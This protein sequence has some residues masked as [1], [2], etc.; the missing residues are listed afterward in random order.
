MACGV[1][2]DPV[3]QMLDSSS[4]VFTFM[5]F[6]PWYPAAGVDAVDLLGKARATIGSSQWQFAIQTADIRTDRP[7]DWVLLDNQQTNNTER[8]ANGLTLSLGPRMF[9]RLGLAFRSATAGV[10]A[11]ADL[12][13]QA[14]FDSCGN[15]LPTYAFHAIA[16]D[17][18]TRFQAVTP[19]VPSRFAAGVKMAIIAS[20]VSGS[21]QY[22]LAQQKAATS[23]ENP[24]N[25]ALI[26]P[27]SWRSGNAEVNTGLV[28]PT[29]TNEFWT[30]FGIAWKLSTGTFGEQDFLLHTIVEG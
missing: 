26:D 19:W 17:T 11:A 21:V 18:N 2:S 3:Q 20:A 24:G 15:R 10:Q 27:L 5:A 22:Q 29:Y 23:K 16:T 4:T 14:A 25:W 30:R 8:A 12:T 7:N 28:S 13:M 1:L 9:F 6:T